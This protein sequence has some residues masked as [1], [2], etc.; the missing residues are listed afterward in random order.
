MINSG[1]A[2]LPVWEQLD[3]PD[4]ATYTA[5]LAAAIDPHLV[6]HVADITERN[7]RLADAPV[8][9][10]AASTIDG[11]VWF[12]ADS[13]WVTWWEPVETWRTLTLESQFSVQ[14]ACQV[15]RIGNQVWLRGRA[16]HD[17]SN[18]PLNGVRVTTVPSDCIPSQIATGAVGIS[19]VGAN[20]VATARLEVYGTSNTTSVGGPGSVSVWLGV[21][22]ENVPWT[23][24][25]CNYWID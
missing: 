1:Y 4:W 2:S 9:T 21:G 15:R 22:Q 14:V 25:N 17:D 16:N 11:S 6:Q 24:L 19:L 23:S 18:I 7:S 20:E 13:G 5:Q 3:A 12:L 10:V 8:G